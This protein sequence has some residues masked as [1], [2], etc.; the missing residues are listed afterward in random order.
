[1]QAT[2][3]NE[4]KEILVHN[5]EAG[6]EGYR[7]FV[8]LNG[9]ADSDNP[10]KAPFSEKEFVYYNASLYQVHEEA[11]TY[12]DSKGMQQQRIKKKETL[13]TNQKSSEPLVVKDLQS[14]DRVYID[15]TQ[16]GIKLDTVKT[17]DKFEPASSIGQYNFFNKFKTGI[18]G[19][20]T[21]GFKM[22]ENT[23]SIGQ[24]LYVLGEAWLEGAKISLG[25]PSEKDKPF[26]VSLRSKSEIVQSNKTGAK[27]ALVFGILLAIAGIML[28]IFVRR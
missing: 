20:K 15:I 21:L 24:P 17:L 27:V 5:R 22:I 23:I 3:I 16:A 4:L 2:P 18:M 19:E 28:M 6:L 26:I 14:Q 25:K 9:F 1:M 13:L 11:E 10:Q 8:E 7:H 12:K